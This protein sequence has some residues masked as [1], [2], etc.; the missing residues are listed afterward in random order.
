MEAVAKRSIIPM[1]Q[2]RA[3][4]WCVLGSAA[5]AGVL[6]AALCAAQPPGG[7]EERILAE[8]FPDVF[9]LDRT[10]DPYMWSVD[11]TGNEQEDLVLLVR[12]KTRVPDAWRRLPIFNP[13]YELASI[14]EVLENPMFQPQYTIRPGERYLLVYH[15]RPPGWR[16]LALTAGFIL[17]DVAEVPPEP[18]TFETP[19]GPAAALKFRYEGKQGLLYWSGERYVAALKD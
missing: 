1:S 2:P 19:D 14:G 7:P 5:L 4:Q 10:A 17:Q 13:P 6:V 11:L 12:S 16:E 3:Q 8:T 9:E 15:A 18:T